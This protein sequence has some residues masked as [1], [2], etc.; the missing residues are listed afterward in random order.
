MLLGIDLKARLRNKAF[1]I[2]MASAVALLAQQLGLNIFPSN[3]EEIV[4]SVLTL[5]A[6][7]GIVVDTSTVGISDKIVNN[8]T[9]IIQSSNS[10]ED[11]SREVNK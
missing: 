3:Y 2:A 4:N 10:T 9:D 5:L 11:E 7:I 8:T 1:W 6:M